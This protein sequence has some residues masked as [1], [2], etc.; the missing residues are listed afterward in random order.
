MYTDFENEDAELRQELFNSLVEYRKQSSLTQVQVAALMGIG[1]PTI[2]E[3]ESG[4]VTPRLSTLQKYARALGLKLEISI[5]E[6]SE[7]NGS[8]D[9]G[10]SSSD[11]EGVLLG[12]VYPPQ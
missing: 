7:I 9:G 4:K 11:S 1:Q 12:V 10:E 3:F 5:V 2:S 6:G 8:N